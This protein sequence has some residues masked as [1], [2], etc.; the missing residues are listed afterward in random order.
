[1]GAAV[2]L[3]APS[4][5]D[6]RSSLIDIQNRA[7]LLN[8]DDDSDEKSARY[9]DERGQWVVDDVSGDVQSIGFPELDETETI[10]APRT[11]NVSTQRSGTPTTQSSSSSSTR[12]RRLHVESALRRHKNRVRLTQFAHTTKKDHP[13]PRCTLAGSGD[14]VDGVIFE[15]YFAY[16][17]SLARKR[18]IKAFEEVAP[19]PQ[20]QSQQTFTGMRFDAK[21]NSGLDHINANDRRLLIDWMR[22]QF[23]HSSSDVKRR[24]RRRMLEKRRHYHSRL[25][26][27]PVTTVCTY[28]S[29]FHLAVQLFDRYATM[30]A[31]EKH[32][33]GRIRRHRAQCVATACMWI[34]CKYAGEVEDPDVS[35]ML[36]SAYNGTVC[37]MITREELKEAEIEI[38]AALKFDLG[39]PS[40]YDLVPCVLIDGL[41]RIHSIVDVSKRIRAERRNHTTSE[42][43]CQAE[44]IGKT[45]TTGKRSREDEN[46]NVVWRKNSPA[47]VAKSP[48]YESIDG[49][50]NRRWKRFER[51][52][53]IVER[54]SLLLCELSLYDDCINVKSPA[55]VASSC[56]V[57]ARAALHGRIPT[58]EDVGETWPY[59]PD[60]ADVWECS[61]R[62]LQMFS[63]ATRTSPQNSPSASPTP[64]RNNSSSA[65]A[66][67]GGDDDE[68]EDEQIDLAMQHMVPRALGTWHHD[69]QALGI[70][71][72]V[73]SNFLQWATAGAG[74]VSTASPDTMYGQM[75]KMRM[76]WRGYDT[77]PFYQ[78]VGNVATLLNAQ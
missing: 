11:P 18:T 35:D 47:P 19:Q 75:R 5:D 6:K 29:T 21:L 31:G 57:L 72:D 70:D 38:L 76:A 9:D 28:E 8:G 56:V 65:A 4:S 60:D 23:M 14:P 45:L 17:I 30:K 54:V 78:N 34:A 13:P 33:F 44:D 46:G 77:H 16:Q 7:S 49:D 71:P 63:A 25:P 37:A 24:R 73:F 69:L 52:I 74:N 2:S 67:G 64:L 27:F 3:Q 51:A 66:E 55:I 12:R 50:L 59:D 20:P 43:Y 40:A 1:M 68:R 39:I 15:E 36:G 10:V 26:D 42:Y 22:K 41:R 62:M 61:Q 53:D 48:S 58:H 32:N